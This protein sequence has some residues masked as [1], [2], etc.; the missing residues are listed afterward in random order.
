MRR[1]FVIAVLSL[2][3]CSTAPDQVRYNA[4][5]EAMMQKQLAGKVA[6]KAVDCLPAHVTADM[7]RVDDD[8]LLFR[9]GSNRVYRNELVGSCSGLGSQH[10]AL[11]TNSIGG[12]RLCRGDIARLVDL[13][14]GIHAGSC[15]IGEFVPYVGTRG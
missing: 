14:S 2:A 5:G 9:A 6:G 11:V 7:I 1:L 15:V 3:G 13:T 4:Q 12:G 8:T 10:Y